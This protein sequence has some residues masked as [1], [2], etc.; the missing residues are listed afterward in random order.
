MFGSGLTLRNW[1]ADGNV[2]SKTP[3]HVNLFDS[4]I[5]KAGKSG[6][7]REG[8]ILVALMSGGDYIP[9]GIPGCGPKTACEAARAGFGAD[10][11]KIAKSD[12]PGYQSWKE[13]L[14]HELK[15]NESKLFKQRHKTLVIPEDFPRSDVLGYYT[16]PVVSP[17]EKIERLR[18]TVKWDQ[19]IDIPALREFCAEAFDWTCIGGAKKFVR[20]LAP[21]LL[22]KQLRLHSEEEPQED[23]HEIGVIETRLVKSIYKTREHVTTDGTPEMRI[24]FIPIGLVNI[25]LEAEE[26]DPELPV[27]DVDSDEEVPATQRADDDPEA[28]PTSPKKKRA[29][30]QYDPTQLEKVWVLE[31]FIRI[32][33]PMK[34][35]DWEES[36]RNAKQYEAMKILRKR[37]EEGPKKAKKAPMPQ[38]SINRYAKVTKPVTL[39]LDPVSQKT[40]SEAVSMSQPPSSLRVPA[41]TSIFGGEAPS[42]LISP[43]ISPFSS[44]QPL[45]RRSS[46]S[47]DEDQPKPTRTRAPGFRMP[48]V[49][50]EIPATTRQ[51]PQ[52]EIIDLLSSPPQRDVMPKKRRLGRSHSDTSTLIE[53]PR[54]PTP[55]R[56]RVVE[57]EPAVTPHESP[58]SALET[59]PELPSSVTTRRKRSPLR[60][61]QTVPSPVVATVPTA[62]PV[63]ESS[64]HTPPAKRQ[65]L[66]RMPPPL[67]SPGQN[68]N[69]Q[70][71]LFQPYHSSSNP[72]QPTTLP[73]TPSRRTSKRSLP[74]KSPNKA[75]IITLSSSPQ[76]P[77]RSAQKSITSWLVS[78]SKPPPSLSPV[79]HRSCRRPVSPQYIR[80]GITPVAAA[81]WKQH[82]ARKRVVRLRES[83]EGAC[84]IEDV[85]DDMLG[86]METLGGDGPVRNR[87][88]QRKG[89]G[90]RKPRSWRLSDMEVLDLTAG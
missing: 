79:S 30:S 17:D 3:T 61:T 8:M 77:S 4:N 44:T 59:I 16:R 87:R 43:D 83:L 51:T 23:P 10:L 41:N 84:T 39:A 46:Y 76:T 66:F 21:A 14:S 52:L 33:V 88:G 90:G 22:V 74:A 65:Y 80:N 68:P 2:A 69:S 57:P 34:V 13:R 50:P 48:A 27:D 85:E 47:I 58:D 35:Q 70:Q 86:M 71:Q 53:R 5:T 20:N 28:E 18:N 89:K 6:L 81:A 82:A 11:C 38:A 73:P 31:T 64:S 49:L 25:D 19:N 60:R 7:D 40:T 78:P 37:A 15:T 54:L 36:L 12:K 63:S 55:P 45:P 62:P 72:Q 75:E 42:E 32:G 29:P 1:S 67:P 26:P 24:G 56:S 9:E